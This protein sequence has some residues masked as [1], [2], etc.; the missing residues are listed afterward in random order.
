MQHLAAHWRRDLNPCLFDHG[1][2][3]VAP[4]DTPAVLA[5]D[6]ANGQILWQS[7]FEVEDV[8]YLLGVVGDQLLAGGQR[9]YWIGLNSAERGRVKH[10][11]PEGAE[12]PGYG[13]GI[14]AGDAVYWPTREKIYVFDQKTA[15]PRKVL[16]L[17]AWGLHGG[18]LVA[19]GGR[20]FI[21]TATELVALGPPQNEKPREVENL[22][23]IRNTNLEIRNKYRK[24]EMVM[25]KTIEP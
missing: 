25:I 16:D 22:T 20:L 2:L 13:R 18:N 24:T 12:R 14:L 3:L 9:L 19:G 11:W 8:Q 10:L 4:T 15:Q 1:T 21:A 6:A 17:A 5:L 23:K 7:G